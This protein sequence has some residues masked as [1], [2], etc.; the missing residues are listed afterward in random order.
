MLL[1]GA[2]AWAISASG[3]NIGITLGGVAAVAASLAMSL[4]EVRA[5]ER[6]ALILGPSLAVRPAGTDT[7]LP[8]FAGHNLGWAVWV[9]FRRTDGRAC[10]L[11]LLADSLENPRQWRVLKA[12]ILHRVRARD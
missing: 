10:R 8:V 3:A 2:A 4:R 7:E 11:M 6:F 12:W 1:H 9:G 5:T